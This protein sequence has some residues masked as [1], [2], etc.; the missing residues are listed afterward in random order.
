VHPVDL[1]L[2]TPGLLALM[3]FA[4]RKAV[5]VVGLRESP[6]TALEIRDSMRAAGLPMPDDFKHF[7]PSR[8]RTY[9]LRAG[10]GVLAF[11]AA[12]ALTLIG[13]TP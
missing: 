12:R 7:V 1:I 13:A 4:A 5:T 9:A 8:G 10:W 11:A 2:T 6:T 3:I